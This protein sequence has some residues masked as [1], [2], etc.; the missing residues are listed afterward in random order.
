MPE[1]PHAGENLVHAMLVGRSDHFFIL[2]RAARLDDRLGPRF[3]RRIDAVTK[4]IESIRGDYRSPKIE[5]VSLG[6]HDRDFCRIHPA[7]L[8]CPYAQDLVTRGKNNGVRLH[9]TANAPGKIQG[10]VLLLCRLAPGHDLTISDIDS[11]AVEI[12]N[13]NIPSHPPA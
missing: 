5:P 6:A 10:L 3:C 12:L 2:D 8:P 4:R 7:H 1:M 13:Q 11:S 9:M